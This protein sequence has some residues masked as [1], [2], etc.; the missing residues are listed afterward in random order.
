MAERQKLLNAHEVNGI[1]RTLVGSSSTA[2]S[3]P[4]DDRARLTYGTT[5][6]GELAECTVYIPG[7]RPESGRVI[8]KYTVDRRTGIATKSA[9]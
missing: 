2:L 9:T 5:I 4:A 1:V 3:L 6:D 7:D 8:A